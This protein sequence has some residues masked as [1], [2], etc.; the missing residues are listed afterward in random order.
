MILK[1]HN[2]FYSYK[3]GPHSALCDEEFYDAMET[4]LDKIDEENEIKDRLKQKSV[5]IPTTP[6]TPA[7]KHKLWPEVGEAKRFQLFSELNKH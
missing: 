3:E 4:G 6:T 7:V 5:A 2:F 1:K